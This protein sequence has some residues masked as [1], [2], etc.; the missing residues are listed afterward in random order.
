MLA[1]AA[2]ADQN[3]IV[4]TPCPPLP[5]W[6]STPSTAP[7]RPPARPRGCASWRCSAEA[8]LTVS[9]LTE[10]LRQSQP[11][12]SRHLSC[13]SKP[14]WSS[15]SAKA[16]GRSSGSADAAAAREFARALIARLDPGRSDDRARPRAA[17][18]GAR[19]ARRRR[20]G[21]FPPPRRASGTASASCMSPTRRSRRRSAARSPATAVPVA[22][23]SR[24]RH[25][26][27]ARNVRP[28]R[29]S[30]ASASTCRSTCWRW[31]APVSTAPG[32]AIAACA[33]A[34]STTSRCRRDSFDVVIIHQVL[35]FLD[36]GARAI[37]EAARVLRAG[38]PPA[39]GRFRAARSGVPAR[40]A[41]ASAPRL[42]RRRP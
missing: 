38:R 16:P 20:A 28:A 18:R 3:G 10:I 34:T 9:D 39:G 22:A 6:L 8:E 32:C 25:R 13:W 29:S 14:A 12:I 2:S 5:T 19:G 15:A 1:K 27:D 21:L 37:R 30:A 33:R 31:R 4:P 36:D 26:P 7:S 42:R 41:R 11:R 40:G 17:R 24:H 23:R 35:H